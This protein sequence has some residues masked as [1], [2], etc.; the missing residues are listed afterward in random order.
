MVPSPKMQKSNLFTV[1]PLAQQ[2]LACVY[3]IPISQHCPGR[4][5]CRNRVLPHTLAFAPQLMHATASLFL[6]N[7]WSGCMQGFSGIPPFIEQP[8]CHLHDR[9]RMWSRKYEQRMP[10]G[11]VR[12]DCTYSTQ[13]LQET[14]NASTIVT[15]QGCWKDALQ[16]VKFLTFEPNSCLTTLT[17]IS[18]SNLLK[19]LPC[20]WVYQTLAPT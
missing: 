17:S 8:K 19:A 11:L 14:C 18:A 15:V 5:F 10:H 16:R 12:V 6:P 20:R 13:T 9:G 4:P 1:H 2:L 7:I 3:L